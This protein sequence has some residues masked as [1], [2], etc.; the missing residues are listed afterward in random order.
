MSITTPNIVILAPYDLDNR[1]LA[2]TD[3]L[4]TVA[5]IGI[6][7]SV[8]DIATIARRDSLAADTSTAAPS[9]EKVKNV[10]NRATAESERLQSGAPAALGI[11]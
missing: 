3:K 5:I 2:V 6:R 8:R 7:D 1:P 4:A 9:G 11:T 10:P